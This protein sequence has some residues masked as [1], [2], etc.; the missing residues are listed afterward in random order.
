MF[1][2]DYNPDSNFT[3]DTPAH[4]T[5]QYTVSSA[6]PEPQLTIT[7]E[8]VIRLHALGVSLGEPDVH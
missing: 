6:S 7:A 8:D 3:F 2:D 1:C 5:Q 4:D